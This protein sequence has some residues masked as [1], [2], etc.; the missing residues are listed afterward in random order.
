MQRSGSLWQHAETVTP[1]SAVVIVLPD[2]GPAAVS[3][4]PGAGGSAKLELSCAPVEVLRQQPELAIWTP[5]PQGVAGVVS[6]PTTDGLLVP[7]TALRVTAIGQPCR[8]EFC[9]QC[10]IA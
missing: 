10:L 4:A 6:A 5:W 1:A 8:I 3:L 2:G 9:Q 7:F